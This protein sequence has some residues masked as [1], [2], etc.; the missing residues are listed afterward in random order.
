[1]AQNR[2][3]RGLVEYEIMSIETQQDFFGTNSY[4]CEHILQDV[5]GIATH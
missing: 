2:R 1:M 3:S 4:V 5:F